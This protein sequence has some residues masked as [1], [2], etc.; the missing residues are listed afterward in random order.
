MEM[1][2]FNL[3]LH[4]IRVYL[5]KDLT[6]FRDF[7]SAGDLRLASRP[8]VPAGR[9]GLN[10]GVEL[11]LVT[12]Q[13]FTGLDETSSGYGVFK[14]NPNAAFIVSMPTAEWLTAFNMKLGLKCTVLCPA[15]GPKYVV[16]DEK[17]QIIGCKALE[18][19]YRPS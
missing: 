2:I 6:I 3:T 12:A 1:P 18:M 10:L 17:G 9:D 5:D 16:R 11:P 19:H 8:Q 15:T 14:A 4:M 13:S 7:P